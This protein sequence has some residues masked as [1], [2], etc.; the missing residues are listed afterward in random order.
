MI[1]SGGQ[2][3]IIQNDS[4]NEVAVITC[5]VEVLLR[6][7]KELEDTVAVNKDIWQKSGE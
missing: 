1:N 2:K 5:Y 6:V 7:A 4:Q 3:I